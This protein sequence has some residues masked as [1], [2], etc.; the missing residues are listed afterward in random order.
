M[1]DNS[2]TTRG[3]IKLR[4][5]QQIVSVAVVENSWWK[6]THSVTAFQKFVINLQEIQIMLEMFTKYAGN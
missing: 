6:Y 1:N 2:T 4:T 3:I 5:S